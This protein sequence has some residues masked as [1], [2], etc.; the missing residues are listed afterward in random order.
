MKHSITYLAML[1]AFAFL[2][3]SIYA[4]VP[5]LDDKLQ[6]IAGI[7]LAF[8]LLV[9]WLRQA[10]DKDWQKMCAE[11]TTMQSLMQVILED[12][13]AKAENLPV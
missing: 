13:K 12:K 9:V 7:I 1:G 6:L 10:N 11:L 2:A 4:V 8:G 3:Y 5:D